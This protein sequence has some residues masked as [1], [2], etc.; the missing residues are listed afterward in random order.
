[1]GIQNKDLPE[2][3]CTLKGQRVCFDRINFDTKAQAVT[4][5]GYYVECDGVS[6]S[7]IKQCPGNNSCKT[8]VEHSTI[9]STECGECQN[10]GT[11]CINGKRIAQ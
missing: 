5:S 11:T 4:A 9:Y 6:W 10:D 7:Q 2:L 1:M 8:Y 3:V